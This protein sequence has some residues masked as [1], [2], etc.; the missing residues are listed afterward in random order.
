MPG[1]SSG[2]GDDPDSCG[3][4]VWMAVDWSTGTGEEDFSS[5]FLGTMI[6]EQEIILS[7]RS[8]SNITI[9]YKC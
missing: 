6:Y 8:I 5:I 9:D 2:A 3:G 7:S 4:E 1:S